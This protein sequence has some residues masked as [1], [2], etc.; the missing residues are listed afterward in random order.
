MLARA[1]AVLVVA[2]TF[3]AAESTAAQ[4]RTQN[5][6][7]AAVRR[8]IEA[9]GE[10]TQAKNL[11]AIDTLFGSSRGV[12]IIEGAGVNHGWAE[13][14]DSHLK[15][16]LD[17]FQNFQY[18]FSSVEAQVRANVAWAAFRYELL[19]DTSNGHIESEGRGT[20][21]L[22]KQNNRWVIVHLHTSG[23]RRNPSNGG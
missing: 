10:F 15:P 20:A 23:R 3:A 4:E 5:P 13:Y 11:A 17:Q 14:R 1:V 21:V 16:E 8:V 7:V 9:F 19:A 18:R 12:H 22:E 2:T 6:E